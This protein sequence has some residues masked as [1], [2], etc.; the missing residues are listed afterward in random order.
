MENLKEPSKKHSNDPKMPLENLTFT[1]FRLTK[2]TKL[3]FL[4][5]GVSLVLVEASKTYLGYMTAFWGFDGYQFLEAARE[6]A[7]SGISRL[8]YLP[9]SSAGLDIVYW[10]HHF[11]SYLYSILVYFFDIQF[12]ELQIVH[13]IEFLLLVWLLFYVMSRFALR[14]HALVL[15]CLILYDHIFRIIFI[16]KVYMRWAFIF[17]MLAFLC[18]W[19]VILAREKQKAKPMQAYLTGFFAAMSPISFVSLGL[20]VTLAI[21]LAFIIENFYYQKTR[22]SKL[23]HF[24][25]FIIGGLTPPI[26]FFLFILANMG[27]GGLYD[28]YDAIS[29]YGDIATS[30]PDSLRTILKIGFFL[31]TIVIPRYGLSLMPIGIMATI[32]NA[33]RW[34]HLSQL[35]KSLVW[36]TIVFTATWMACAMFISTHFYSAR[37]IWILPLYVLQIL[38]AWRLKKINMTLHYWLLASG[39]ILILTQALYHSLGKPGGQYGLGIAAFVA[40]AGIFLVIWLLRSYAENR[41]RFKWQTDKME[42]FALL[43]IVVMLVVPKILYDGRNLSDNINFFLQEPVFGKEPLAPRLSRDVKKVASQELKTG[44]RVLTNAPVK[45]FFAD[46]VERQAIYFYRGLFGGATREPAD[47]MFLIAQGDSQRISDYNRVQVGDNVYYRGFTYYLE[48]RVEL[49]EGYYLL[50]GPPIQ[51]DNTAEIVYPN[52]YIPKQEVEQFLESLEFRD[53]HNN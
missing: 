41:E 30:A 53:L 28:T 8:S 31:A 9:N 33:Y 45:E 50:I 24:F 27:V 25:S 40:L 29:R 19:R 39:M 35:E 38:I 37:M 2:I 12:N 4:L 18:L 22:Q 26:I 34:N 5:L 43:A 10:S 1:K 51:L 6:L 7:L 44:D 46:G 23:T 20:P 21:S 32:L 3:L 11:P 52:A 48:K 14:S 42:S 49:V 13:Y 36:I 16:D 17:A 15:T 47:K